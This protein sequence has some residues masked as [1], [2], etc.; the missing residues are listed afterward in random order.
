MCVCACVCREDRGGLAAEVTTLKA[1]HERALLDART[2]YVMSETE[3][4]QQMT[5]EDQQQ[6]QQ[7]SGD[8]LQVEKTVSSAGCVDIAAVSTT[9][10]ELK[11][12]VDKLSSMITEVCVVELC[13]SMVIS[14]TLW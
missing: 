1:A 5:A 12:R 13:C 2:K 8:W 10:I 9:E 3:R 4:Q 14:I 11:R 6:L 7:Q